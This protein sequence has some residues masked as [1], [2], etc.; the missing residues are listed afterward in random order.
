MPQ[1]FA[2]EFKF[3]LDPFQQHAVAAISRDE[4]VLVTAK[5]GSGK[6]LAFVLPMLRHIVD[7]RALEAGEGPIALLLTP[8]RELALQIHRGA[9]R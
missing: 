2:M 8:T 7:Q 4:N 1:T 5:T 9:N 6:T 3:P